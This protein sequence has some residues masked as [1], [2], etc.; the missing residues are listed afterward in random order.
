VLNDQINR[1]SEIDTA[2][3][4][5]ASH[6]NKILFCILLII[7]Q[8]GNFSKLF[9]HLELVNN[10]IE[11]VVTFQHGGLNNSLDTMTEVVREYTKGQEE[12]QN[13]RKSLNETQ[14]VLTAKKAGQT[15]LRELW[16]KKIEL[17]ESIRMV[18]EIEELKV[19][20]FFDVFNFF[21]LNKNIYF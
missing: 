1:S 13:L 7:I 2:F 6:Y 20:V 21:I 11:E 16:M 14:K 12:I 8:G 5:T 10:V 15:S 17:Q 3:K 19:K 4:V 18:R 9:N